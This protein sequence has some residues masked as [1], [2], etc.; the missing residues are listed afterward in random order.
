MDFF[1]PSS[2]TFF[3]GDILGSKLPEIGLFCLLILVRHSVF[4]MVELSQAQTPFMVK[5]HQE[6]YQDNISVSACQ[7][8]GVSERHCNAPTLWTQ[9]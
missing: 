2:V 3:P 7:S 8:G 5:T 4:V 1:H 9:K 6:S